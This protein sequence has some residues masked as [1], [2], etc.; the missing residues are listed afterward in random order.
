MLKRVASNC[1]VWI[2]LF[3]IFCLGCANSTL[4]KF[5]NNLSQE[6]VY[7]FH[8]TRWGMSQ[9]QVEYSEIEQKSIIVYRTPETLIYKCR[10]GDVKALRIYTFKNNNLR[11]AGYVTQYP[12]KGKVD[13]R[14]HVLSEEKYGTPTFNQSN[15]YV[16][17][18]GNSVIYA[19]SYTSYVR[20]VV[21]STLPTSRYII[22][23]VGGMFAE[24]DSGLPS[25]RS[26]HPNI[27]HRWSSVWSYTDSK[28]YDEIYDVKFPSHE[29]SRAEQVL[30][31]LKEERVILDM[32][33]VS[34]F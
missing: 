9:A 23:T 2:F 31:G 17:I 11:C 24:L 28:F 26:T 12:V 25:K 14:F 19:K 21:P 6:Q 4:N 32:I 8:K 15:G 16:W 29:L 18:H 20:L 33:Q 7:D 34:V 10:L 13:N 5:V 1:V 30:F 3:V 22:S 27:I